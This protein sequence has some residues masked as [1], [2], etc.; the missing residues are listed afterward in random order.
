MVGLGTAVVAALLVLGVTLLPFRRSELPIPQTVTVEAG[1]V[2]LPAPPAAR[3]PSA[4]RGS[5]A[6]QPATGAG[7]AQ[8]GPSVPSPAGPDQAA[9]GSAT[10][11]LEEATPD[12]RLNQVLLAAFQRWRFFPATEHGQP[13][14]STLVL[15]V[16]IKVE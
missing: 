1:L 8:A 11:E 16:P 4:S 6:A 15:R 2:E 3:A 12:P 5:A 14:A 13:V 7:R 9:D 10:A